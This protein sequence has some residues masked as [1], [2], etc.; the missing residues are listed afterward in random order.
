MKVKDEPSVWRSVE[1]GLQAEQ[2]QR[3]VVE[4][5]SV[6]SGDGKNLGS[7]Q[8]CQKRLVL[9]ALGDPDGRRLCKA[10]ETFVFCFKQNGTNYSSKQGSHII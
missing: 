10:G 6:G 7:G 8:Y 5:S 1:G 4:A 9:C 3:Q 2:Q